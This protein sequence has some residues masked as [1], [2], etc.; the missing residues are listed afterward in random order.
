[1]ISRWFRADRK[2]ESKNTDLRQRVTSDNDNEEM[3]SPY[4][5]S[6][7]GSNRSEA[8]S[9]FSCVYF[10][11]LILKNALVR[12][13]EMAQWLRA[14]AAFARARSRSQNPQVGS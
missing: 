8:A 3:P 12:A 5:L 13:V 1:M 11:L 7:W 4:G 14:F 2:M 10:S 9:R 6:V